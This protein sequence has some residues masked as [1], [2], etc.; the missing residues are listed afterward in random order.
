[1]TLNRRTSAVWATTH[2]VSRS[3][4]YG[5]G[6]YLDIVDKFVAAVR[7]AGSQAC[8]ILCEFLGGR[9]IDCSA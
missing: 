8:D 9:V 6:N 2:H 1:M 5:I 7:Y 4:L 3:R